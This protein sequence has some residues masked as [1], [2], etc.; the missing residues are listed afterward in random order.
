[1]KPTT[2]SGAYDKPLGAGDNPNTVPLPYT[3]AVNDEVYTQDG[4][5]FMVSCWELSGE[6][7]AEIIKTG[8]IYLSVMSGTQRPT[9]PPVIITAENPQAIGYKFVDKEFINKRGFWAGIVKNY[10]DI[11]NAMV[12]KTVTAT[13]SDRLLKGWHKKATAFIKQAP[14]YTQRLE[15]FLKQP[16]K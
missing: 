6:D 2:F 8:K 10:D 14:E 4:P 15:E 1:M 3:L 7:L 11:L 12:T 13:E 9:Q 16:V 5:C